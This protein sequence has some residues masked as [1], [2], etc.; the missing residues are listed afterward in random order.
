MSQILDKILSS[1]LKRATIHV[2]QWDVEIGLRELTAAESLKFGETSKISLMRAM[3]EMVISCAFDPQTDKP[4]FEPAH[5]DV[6]ETKSGAALKTIAEKIT[7]LSGMN[8]KGA[9]ELEKN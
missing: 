7:E 6:L 2:P 4:L 8:E 3:A 9:A 5:R 1:Q